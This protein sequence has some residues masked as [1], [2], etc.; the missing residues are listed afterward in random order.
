MAP[1]K[2]RGKAADDYDD[3]D[4]A[5]G[6]GSD[7]YNYYANGG[8]SMD[9]NSQRGG[10]YYY[11]DDDD[12]YLRSSRSVGRGDPYYDD[13]SY[14]YDDSYDRP[15]RAAAPSDKKSS[16]RKKASS[17]TDYYNNTGAN[18]YYNDNDYDYPAQ[19]TKERVADDDPPPSRSRKS[20]AEKKQKGNRSQ[21]VSTTTGPGKNNSNY[22][23]NTKNNNNYSKNNN[24]NNNNNNTEEKMQTKY[25][26]D[27]ESTSSSSSDLYLYSSGEGREIEALFSS[28]VEKVILFEM[29]KRRAQFHTMQSLLEKVV[30]YNPAFFV[31]FAHP[32]YSAKPSAWERIRGDIAHRVRWA[33]GD[34]DIRNNFLGLASL[35]RIGDDMVLKRMIERKRGKS[36]N[37]TLGLL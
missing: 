1:P 13:A 4:Y 14:D 5:N 34:K 31:H 17:T 27:S 32:Y 9:M 35:K 23:Y 37:V 36:I 18:G 28:I 19:D 20:R 24:N 12:P 30:R 8:A 3:Y 10:D 11:G 29:K 33:D 21:K 22:N 6:G 7:P 16:R 15:Q 26:G 25:D 2:K